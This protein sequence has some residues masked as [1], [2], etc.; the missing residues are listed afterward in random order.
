MSPSVSTDDE[1][2]SSSQDDIFSSSS[3]ESIPEHEI[4]LWS[5]EIEEQG[6]KRE[7]LNSAITSLTSGRMSQILST[8]NTS[9]EDISSTQKKYYQRK[10]KEAIMASLSVISPGQEQELWN[11]VRTEST[12]DESSQKKSRRKSIDPSSPVI[13]SLVKA[14]DHADS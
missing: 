5:D 1:Q 6:K 7:T 3:Q 11:A 2:E 10:A 13:D 12:T 9:W 8:L 4:S 14:Y